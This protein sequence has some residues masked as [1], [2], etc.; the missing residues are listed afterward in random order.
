MDE[1][2][3]VRRELH[4]CGE[5]LD[6]EYVAGGTAYG[7]FLSLGEGMVM[8]LAKTFSGTKEVTC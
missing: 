3:D 5:P 7:W 1:T 8:P 6:G 4:E 2:T